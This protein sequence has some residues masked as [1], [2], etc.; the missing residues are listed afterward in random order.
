MKIFIIIIAFVTTCAFAGPIP[1]DWISPEANQKSVKPMD[2][3]GLKN[4]FDKILGFQQNLINSNLDK[5]DKK[6][7]LQ[8]IKTELGVEAEG[9]IGLLGAGGE[10][11]L[12]L[13]WIKKQDP[14]RGGRTKST[15]GEEL[16]ENADEVIG[17]H[18]QMSEQELM[19][20]FSPVIKI[21]ERSG[22]VKNST[23]M[24][25]EL[26]SY[27]LSFQDVT[28][29]I[30]A[31]PL[32]KWY[33]YKYQLEL[34][35]SVDGKVSP[36]AKVGSK[37]RVRME[38][39][40]L[41]NQNSQFIANKTI[42]ANSNLI[43][44]LAQDLSLLDSAKMDN[45]FKLNTA[46]IGIGLGLEG[47]IFVAKA[48]A[49]VIGSLF[50]L[51]DEKTTAKEQL[52]T[53]GQYQLDQTVFRREN[54]QKGIRKVSNIASVISTLAGKPKREDKFNLNVIE[55]EFEIFA[56]GGIGLLTAK[57]IGSFVVFATRGVVI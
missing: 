54:F 24:A 37:F 44:S 8:S 9:E 11:A 10:A 34:Y 35:V 4:R 16:D 25:Q 20:Q 36:I 52:S 56:E 26:K 45:D 23:L 19:N 31:S 30:E 55:I 22:M 48:K 47:N 51:K 49:N 28:K 57:G 50:F 14:T 18:S 6:W 27:A 17:I 2:I 3:Q 32:T 13:V 33:V 53:S 5:Q 41:K 46:K 15:L 7:K 43:A 38:W 1:S 42:K 21:A 12:E 29:A 40:R 39:W